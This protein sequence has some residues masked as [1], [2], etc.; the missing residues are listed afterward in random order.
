MPVRIQE[1]GGS[2]LE[3]YSEGSARR[4]LFLGLSVP[5]VKRRVAGSP[6]D[7]W[8]TFCAWLSLAFLR[9]R[10]K[11]ANVR[12]IRGSNEIILSPRTLGLS[13]A[14]IPFDMSWSRARGRD[15]TH[16]L[17]FPYLPL[18]HPASGR[19]KFRD[20]GFTR[21]QAPIFAQPPIPHLV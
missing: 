11:R 3:L 2:G 18:P 1:N 9:K 12:E 7:H 17:T 19:S 5:V 20:L 13:F 8:S 16:L 14:G 6:G 21:C 4:D 10:A 15:A